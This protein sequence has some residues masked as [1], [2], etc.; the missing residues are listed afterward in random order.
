HF[1]KVPTIVTE[2]GTTF[3]R[4]GLDTYNPAHAGTNLLGTEM[5]SNQ[6]FTMGPGTEFETRIRGT[7]IPRGVVYSFFTYKQRNFGT[8]PDQEEIDNEF[9]GNQATNQFWLNIWNNG[10]SWS[11][12]PTVSGVDSTT[13]NTYKIRWLNDR[14]E[15]W[16]NNTLVRTETNLMPDDYMS[17]CYNIWAA[18][19]GW[20]TA[21]DSNLP[22]SNSAAANTTYYFDV[23]YIRVRTIAPTG[24]GVTGNGTGLSGV[25]FNNTTL[26]NPTLTKQ[27]YRIDY[28]WG[29]GSPDPSIGPDNWSARW[30]GQVQAQYTEPYTFYANTDDGVRLYVNNQLIINN[31]QAG[32][33]TTTGTINLTAGQWYDFRMEYFDGT[34]N[35]QAQLYWSSPST[36]KQLV[37]TTQLSPYAATPVLS[38]PAGT[39]YTPQTITVSDATPGADIHYTL[40]GTDPTRS[41]PQIASGATLTFNNSTTLKVAAWHDGYF[42]SPINMAVYTIVSDP[43]PPTVSVTAPIATYSYTSLPQA[44]GTASDSGSGV[45]S[46]TGRLFRFSDNTYWNGSAWTATATELPGTGTTNW[47]VK[48]PIL[49]DGHYTFRATVRDAAGNSTQSS[50]ADFYIDTVAP[51]ITITTPTAASFNNLPQAAGTAVDTGPGVAQVTGRLFRYSDN[52]YWNGSAWTAT[53]AEVVATGTNNWTLPLPPLA[54]GKYSFRASAS[55]YVG[56]KASTTPFDFFIDTTPPTASVTT[57]PLNASYRSLAQAAGTAGDAFSGV[58]QVRGRLYRYADGA[59]WNG[60]GWVPTDTDS[61]AQGTANWTFNLPALADGKYSFRAAAIDN[62]GNI[63]YSGANDFFIDNVPPSLAVSL[64]TA[65]TLYASGFT[66]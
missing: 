58:A 30:S 33:T 64:P 13:W 39:Y 51:S 63:G 65:N 61:P 19:S 60:S 31:W 37:P 3:A 40:D 23:D 26:T 14:V 15:W 18:D 54:D 38:V 59:F 48:L 8:D 10:S 5:W 32:S 47:A 20:S 50:V 62:A 9:L 49:P 29:S 11:T 6:Q 35:A 24:T 55:D 1:G 25:Y 43:I 53:A 4:F 28:N 2:N 66:A 27:A 17:V 7:N 42:T 52:T 46:V 45:Q 57:P 36:P 44:T 12:N 21:Y 22:A 34:G 41:S 16:I 56:N